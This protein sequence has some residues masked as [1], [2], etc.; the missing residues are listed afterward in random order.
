MTKWAKFRQLDGTWWNSNFYIFKLCEYWQN[1]VNGLDA[2]G[3][4]LLQCQIYNKGELNFKLL[5]S[6]HVNSLSPAASN[7]VFTDGAIFLSH[8]WNHHRKPMLKS[9]ERWPE[10][11]TV[12]LRKKCEK[13]SRN[14]RLRKKCFWYAQ[15]VCKSSAELGGHFSIVSYFG[16]DACSFTS[17]SLI[18]HAIVTKLSKLWG[19]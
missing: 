9:W 2:N 14:T 6:D 16:A 15:P 7:T 13:R 12:S 4:L 18:S 1:A 8:R 3:N 5:F 17:V 10:S 11:C 19:L